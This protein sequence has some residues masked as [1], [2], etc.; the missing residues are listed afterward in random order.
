[1]LIY[2]GRESVRFVVNDGIKR[3]QRFVGFVGFE[4]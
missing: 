4:C 3:D 2:L 1:M